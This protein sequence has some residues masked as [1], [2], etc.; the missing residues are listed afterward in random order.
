MNMRTVT[1]KD[2]TT[3]AFDQSGEGPT[4]ILV[5]GALQHRGFDPGTA[6]LAAQLAQRFTVFHYDRRGRGDSTDTQPFAVEREIEDIEALVNAGGGSASLFGMSSGGAL[7]MK[8]A[9]ALGDKIKKLTAYEIPYNDDTTARQTWR[10][11]ATNLTAAL[12]ANCP[13][14]AAALFLKLVGTPAEQIEGMRHAPIWSTFEAVAP[15]LAYDAAVLG[16]EA[17][18]PREQAARVRVPAL[19]MSGSASYPFMGETA[20]ALSQ[21]MPHARLRTLEGQTHDVNPEVLAPVLLEFFTE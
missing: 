13:G 8:A 14:D 2:G 20:Q 1:S 4:V 19:V 15:T 6:R 11:Y 12:A 18:V 21:A 7:A 3:I 5:G 16:E 10:E 17:A 9:I